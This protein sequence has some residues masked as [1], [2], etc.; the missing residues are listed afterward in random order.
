[1]PSIRARSLRRRMT[2]SYTM[3]WRGSDHAKRGPRSHCLRVAAYRRPSDASLP[4]RRQGPHL[5]G[6]LL[7]PVHTQAQNR[8]RN[9]PGRASCPEPKP[10][11]GTWLYDA[12]RKGQ[13][14]SPAERFA[15]GLRNGEGFAFDAE[16][17]IHATQQDFDQLREN[18]PRL[19]TLSE[20][21]NEPAEELGLSVSKPI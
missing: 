12:N 14:F 8:F 10:R 21:A 18:R 6:R 13:R 4:H 20:G 2:G 19:Y 3:R 5:C 15:T 1:S 7:C 16:R 9:S 17:R 11:A